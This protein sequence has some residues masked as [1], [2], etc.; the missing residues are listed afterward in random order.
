[1]T[2]DP[3][4]REAALGRVRQ[5]GLGSGKWGAPA[6]DNPYANKPEFQDEES[7]WASGRLD[8]ARERKG[9]KR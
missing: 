1:M 3:L 2:D 9:V 5:A 7:A 8:G 4:S 6:S